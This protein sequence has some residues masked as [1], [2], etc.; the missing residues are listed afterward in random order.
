M[1]RFIYPLMNQLPSSSPNKLCRR[2]CW[3]GARPGPAVT[4]IKICAW[5]ANLNFVARPARPGLYQNSNLRPGR[6]FEFCCPAGP[7]RL[8]PKFKFAPG[9]QI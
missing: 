8:L 1:G 2:R 3:V 5:G 6:K 9:A 7:A 4:K